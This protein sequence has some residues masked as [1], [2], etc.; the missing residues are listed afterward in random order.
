M[1]YHVRSPTFVSSKAVIGVYRLIRLGPGSGASPALAEGFTAYTI[2]PKGLS[3]VAV[4]VMPWNAEG[5]I[6]R[7][8]LALTYSPL[9]I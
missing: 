3:G 8:S 5:R 7:M 4:N 9:L 1:R 2:H 6:T